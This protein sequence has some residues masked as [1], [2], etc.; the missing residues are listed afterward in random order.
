[1]ISGISLILSILLLI[2]LLSILSILLFGVLLQFYGAMSEQRKKTIP[3]HISMISIIVPA[4]NE[5]T[6]IWDKIESIRDALSNIDVAS[7][8]II[9]SDG[10]TDGTCEI[11]R[12]KLAEFNNHNWRLLEFENEGKCSTLNK[13]VAASAGDIVISTDADIPVPPNSIQIILSAFRE[14]SQ[15]GCVSCIPSFK[16]LNIG[17]QNTYWSLEQAN[18]KAESEI[19]KQIVVTGMLY[20]YRRKLFEKI[21]KMVMADDF[22]IPLHVLLKGFECRQLE[23]LLVPYEPTDEATEIERRKRV[24]KGGIDTIIRLWSPLVSTPSIMILVIF[25]KII[26]W[27]LP[28][29]IFLIVVIPF[30][31]MPHIIIFY[32]LGL[33]SITLYMGWKRV[34]SLIVSLNTPLVAFYELWKNKDIGRWEHLRKNIK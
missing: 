15:L 3:S 24:I 33:L 12:L 1:M 8:V 27:M 21:P 14:N 2:G 18:R 20:A 17:S 9:G 4:Y 11:A 6:K 31:I 25:H 34:W 19:G 10:S 26:R 5:E 23:D 7:E 29:W 22:W 28:I 16:G 32:I 30:L 13:L